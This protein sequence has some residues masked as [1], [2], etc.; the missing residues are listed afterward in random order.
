MRRL[1]ATLAPVFALAATGCAGEPPP[2]EPEAVEFF[3]SPQTAEPPERP[4]GDEYTATADGNVIVLPPEP[5][6]PVADDGVPSIEEQIRQCTEQTGHPEECRD[7]IEYG[8]VD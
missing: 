3:E 4:T 1:L 6:P 5:D 2:P 7:K 8:I